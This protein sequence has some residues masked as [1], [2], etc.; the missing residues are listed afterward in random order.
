MTARK[1]R[2]RSKKANHYFTK[3]HENA[4]VEY[5]QI[6][7]VR[8]RTEL[9]IKYIEPAF[10]EMVDKVVFTYKFTSLPNIGSFIR[11]KRP[12]HATA[13]RRELKVLREK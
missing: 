2:G 13:G 8:R 10:S 11:S 5:A 3:V 6:R 12:P 4:I 7:D 1:R 9:Y